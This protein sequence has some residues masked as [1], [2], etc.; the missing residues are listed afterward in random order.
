[1]PKPSRRRIAREIVRL[2]NEQPNRASDLIRQT[3]AYLVQT[4]QTA[5][6]HLLVND[7]ADELFERRGDLNAEVQTAF[8]LADATRA[9]IIAMLKRRTGAKSVSLSEAI[10]PDLIGGVIISTPVSHL[11]A[12]VKRQLKRLAGGIA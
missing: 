12:S 11:D 8:G 7:I 4:K 5:A 1:M 9:S 2:M 6:A 10:N 3:A